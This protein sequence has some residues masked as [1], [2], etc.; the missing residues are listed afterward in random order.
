VSCRTFAFTHTYE[1]FRR[2]A[3]TLQAHLVKNGRQHLLIA[4]EPSGLS[5]QALDERLKSWGDEVCLVHCPAVRNHRQTR[6]DG[7]SQTD[8]T[9][10]YRR[11]DLLRQGTFFLPVARDPAWPAAY[12]LRQRSRA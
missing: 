5:W 7:T 4:M 6:Q 8:E 12:R 1:G 2:F 11:F 3:Q 9:D 10:A